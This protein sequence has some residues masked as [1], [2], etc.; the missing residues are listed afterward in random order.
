MKKTIIIG[1]ACLAVGT[2]LAGCGAGRSATVTT[3]AEAT[4]AAETTAAAETTTAVT[5]AT[6]TTTE[7]PATTTTES[8]T[9]RAKAHPEDDR[10]ME[11]LRNFYKS[12][13]ILDGMPATINK[14]NTIYEYTKF[15]IADFDGDGV[16]EVAI[17]SEQISQPQAGY[18]IVSIYESDVN[19]YSLENSVAAIDLTEL[20][21]L[22]FLDNGVA[23]TS[24]SE[25]STLDVLD[26]KSYYLID[27]GLY[28][29]LN[30]SSDNVGRGGRYYLL[31]FTEGGR[32]FKQLG[33]VQ[34]MMFRVEKSRAEYEADKAILNSGSVMDVQVKDFTAENVG[35]SSADF[36]DTYMGY[37]DEELCKLAY[38][39]FY[40]QAKGTVKELGAEAEIESVD[41]KMV[42]IRIFGNNGQTHT[43]YEVDR[44]T[45]IG[46]DIDKDFNI[47]LSE[48]EGWLRQKN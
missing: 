17:Q 30:Y 41:G 38:F 5:E 24:A 6:T 15:A 44:V 26:D 19:D 28:G 10:I 42:T 33:T 40:N 20:S 37:S 16:N 47:D 14:Y 8:P 13:D 7:A 12:H 31:Y 35:L 2:G 39:Y 3:T 23:Y 22:T 1:V 46:K 4:T 21:D 34:D 11:N 27:Y 18:L 48:Y 9:T 45:G 29:K 43:K 25:H 32:I 36:S